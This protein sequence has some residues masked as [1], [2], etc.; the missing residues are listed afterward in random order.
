MIIAQVALYILKVIGISFLAY[1]IC[2]F[3]FVIFTLVTIEDTLSKFNIIVG[4]VIASSTVIAIAYFSFLNPFAI[5][6]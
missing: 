5:G 3:F 6:G 1:L 2:A 4:C